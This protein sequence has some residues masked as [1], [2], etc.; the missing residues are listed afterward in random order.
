MSQSTRHKM[1]MS[2]RTDI[3][4]VNGK[5][6]D[7]ERIG[8]AKCYSHRLKGLGKLRNRESCDKLSEAGCF[9]EE[10]GKFCDLK[11][12]ADNDMIAYLNKDRKGRAASKAASMAT[13]GA[14]GKKSKSKKGKRSKRK[15]RTKSKNNSY[16]KK[17]SKTIDSKIREYKKVKRTKG[18]SKK[19]MSTGKGGLKIFKKLKSFLKEP[20][21]SADPP[22]MSE[23][24][25]FTIRGED[26]V[27]LLN[28]VQ[29]KIKEISD[30][31]DH[32]VYCSNCNDADGGCVMCHQH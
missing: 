10:D 28:R 19:T 16:L 32:Q 11:V 5:P 6:Y 30:F 26:D 23:L 25:R 20:V 15:G 3:K 18:R 2:N 7:R 21:W 12:G 29:T 8:R 14:I 24:G 9:W 13:K 27:N 4:Y 1:F 31:R 17:L 22:S